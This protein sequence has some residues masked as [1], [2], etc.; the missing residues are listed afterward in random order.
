MSLYRLSPY[1]YVFCW[2]VLAVFSYIYNSNLIYEPLLLYL[3]GTSLFY[4]FFAVNNYRLPSYFKVLFLF[5][6]VLVAYGFLLVFIGNDVYWLA[7]GNYLRKYLYILW[8]ISALLSVVPVYV[9]TCEGLIGEKEMKI[10]FFFFFAACIYAFYGA[11]KIQMLHA[12]IQKLEQ[13]EYTI[14]SVYSFLSIIP[15]VV[16][17]KKKML[18]QFVLLGVMFVYLVLSAKRGAIIL[19]GVSIVLVI[20]NML[21]SSSFEKKIAIVVFSILFLGGVYFFF[22]YQMQTSFYFTYRVNQTLDGY[23]SNRDALARN[24]IDFFFE[25][26]SLFQYFFGLGAQGSLSVNETFTHNDWLAILLEQGLFGLLLYLIYWIGFV[27]SWI[28]S[29]HNREAFAVIG[30]LI[31][32]GLGKTL[33]SMYYL[34]ISPEMMTSSGF[35]AVTLGYYLGIAFPQ[36]RTYLLACN[37]CENKI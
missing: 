10:V 25:K 26:T 14:T 6:G 9:F 18:L 1:L 3:T 27:Y 29:R 24:A 31:F 34:P 33:F 36:H 8:L 21:S 22:N 28:N 11:L 13:E 2:I 35:F 32:V 7:T 20:F 30:I 37:Q 15:L 17:F 23:T 4:T 19:G 5:V 16:L 12:A